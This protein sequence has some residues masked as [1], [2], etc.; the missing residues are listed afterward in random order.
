[1]K[2]GDCFE[3]TEKLLCLSDGLAKQV[4]IEFT[5]RERVV[6]GIALRPTRLWLG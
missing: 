2:G 3:R 4:L 5:G 6:C 1:M